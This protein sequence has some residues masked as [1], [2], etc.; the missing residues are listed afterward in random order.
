[1]SFTIIVT[2]AIIA[3][4]ALFYNPT[5]VERFSGR[6]RCGDKDRCLPEDH[7]L[8]LWCGTPDESLYLKPEE[9][10]KCPK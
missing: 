5:K 3:I 8:D 4:I 7:K 1:M 2:I 10:E 9:R 6:G